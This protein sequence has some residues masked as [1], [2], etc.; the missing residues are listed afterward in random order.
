MKRTV[1]A[2]VVCAGL[3]TVAGAAFAAGQQSQPA[4][5]SEE[6]EQKAMQDGPA[7]PRI[8]YRTY[9]EPAAPARKQAPPDPK[10]MVPLTQR[11]VGMLYNAC[12]A[13]PE[14]KTAYAKAYEHQQ[15]LLRAQKEQAAKS[16]SGS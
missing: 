16:G 6:V 3:G 8:G 10:L 9:M 11:E 15:A 13:Y 1:L 12:V 14:C 5:T 4:P 2:I 7:T